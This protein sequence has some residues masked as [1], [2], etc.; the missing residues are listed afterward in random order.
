[1]L[2]DHAGGNEGLSGF[3]NMLEVYRRSFFE[4]LAKT[5]GLAHLLHNL[6]QWVLFTLF[7]TVRLPDQIPGNAITH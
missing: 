7:H 2:A 4:F 5:R 3:H 1:V 6:C